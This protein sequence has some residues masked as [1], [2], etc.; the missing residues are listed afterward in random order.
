[1]FGSQTLSVV[2]TATE[3]ATDSINVG[4]GPSALSIDEASNRIFVT[5]ASDNSLSVVDGRT[6]R[7]IA[8]LA[9]G[10]RPS[11]LALNTDQKRLYVANALDP[12]LT[13]VDIET[14]AVTDSIA[15][16][17]PAIAVEYG[18]NTQVLY[19]GSNT[20]GFGRS[21]VPGMMTLID[22]TSRQ[23]L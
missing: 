21:Q 4:R 3:R 11:S 14:L 7:Q 12:W 23:I 16:P 17:A 22:P 10:R 6:N 13:V 20:S 1:N 8:V 18:R 2:D 5:N 15:L 19:A 9:T